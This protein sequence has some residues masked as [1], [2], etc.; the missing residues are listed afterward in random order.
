MDTKNLYE[1]NGV[2]YT[3]FMMNGEIIDK[4]CGTSSITE[5]R[6]FRD[7]LKKEIRSGKPVVKK[8]VVKDQGPRLSDSVQK[9]SEHLK[10][11]PSKNSWISTANRIVKLLDDPF[12]KDVNGDTAKNLKKILEGEKKEVGTI[13]Y[14]NKVLGMLC[15]MEGFEKPKL[16][17]A[18]NEVPRER[19]FVYSTQN[20][21]DIFEALRNRTTMHEGNAQRYIDLIT[22]LL[23]TGKRVNE[24]LKIKEDQIDLVKRRIFH[25]ISKGGNREYIYMNETVFEIY[26]RGQRFDKVNL[27]YF[28]KI[29]NEILVELGIKKWD[30]CI[31]TFR[32][33]CISK[34]FESGFQDKMIMQI[35]GHKSVKMLHRYEHLRPTQIMDA[36]N[37]INFI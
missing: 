18:K 8:E 11:S 14:Y 24:I 36:I 33:N 31:H 1:R 23:N 3:K 28:Q 37:S 34:L 30:A 19:E 16:V 21:L 22:V 27:R 4:S 32:H 13:L 17:L 29:L 5:A 9:L 15:K 35:S 26:N 7:K 20:I 6:K 10:G 2:W 12:A 25:T